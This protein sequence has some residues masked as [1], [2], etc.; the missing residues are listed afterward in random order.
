M[1]G[2][3]ETEAERSSVRRV[4]LKYSKRQIKIIERERQR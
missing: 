2:G 1:E 4:S 3:R